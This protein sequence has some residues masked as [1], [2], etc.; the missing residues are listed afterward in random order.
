MIE[1]V[2]V[3]QIESLPFLKFLEPYAKEVTRAIYFI[4]TFPIVY[5]I[6]RVIVW[7]VV[8]RFLSRS[9]LDAHAKQPIR[10]LVT[11][12]L[13]LV[14]LL[15]AL[16]AAGLQELLRSL[17]TITAAGTLAIGF[18][19][20]NVL[21][22]FVAGVFIYIDKPFRI[23]DWIEWGEKETGVEKA[24]IVESISLRVTHVRTFNNE[25]LTVPNTVLTN[26]VIKN[27]VAYETL[28]IPF[29]FGIGYEDDIE[30]AM[31]III[32][33][34]DR[35]DEILDSPEPSV[36]LTELED[37]YVGLTARVWIEEPTR[38]DY[39]SIRSEYVKNVKHSFNRHGIEIPFPQVGLSGG[40]NLTNAAVS[41]SPR[42]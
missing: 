32:E 39:L 1:P 37:S 33:E 27:P 19:M 7:P 24:G 6:G 42:G 13:L 23:G 3:L 15:F 16:S 4:I 5:A 18:G 10:R 17:S 36:K 35:L 41:E 25:L 8:D 28:R 31:E 26:D 22:N 11:G 14:A 34:A 29:E 2:P 40:V 21:S 38:A 12:G 9:D 20:Q 30:R